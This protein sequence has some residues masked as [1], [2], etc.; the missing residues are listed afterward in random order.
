MWAEYLVSIGEDSNG[1]TKTFEAW[2]FGD[3]ETMAE[4]IAD[5]VLSGAKRATA[6]ALE[7]YELEGDPIPQVGDYSV[8]TDFVGKARC[9]IRSSAV[10]VVGYNEVTSEFAATEGEGDGSLEYWQRE[11]WKFFTREFAGIGRQP[12]ED[13]LI[14]CEQF[15]V[16]YPA[17]YAS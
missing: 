16:V 10:E 4:E 5:L 2:H 15:E 11:H 14:V 8:I 6:G 17:A 1:T 13:M 12:T 3:S 7:M 9:V